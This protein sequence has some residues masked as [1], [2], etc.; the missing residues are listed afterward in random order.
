MTKL[1]RHYRSTQ[2]Y[3]RLSVAIGSIIAFLHLLSGSSALGTGEVPLKTG[4]EAVL[5]R[6]PGRYFR[7]VLSSFEF[8]FKRYFRSSERYYR[9][10]QSK[11]LFPLACLL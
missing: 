8:F 7:L 3:Y 11:C 2:R 4:G 10:K 1:K 6:Y 5:K 9:P